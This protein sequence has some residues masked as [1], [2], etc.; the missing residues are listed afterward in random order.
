MG[1]HGMFNFLRNWQTAFQGGGSCT[2]L[3]FCQ[4]CVR[5]PVPPHP[6]QLLVLSAF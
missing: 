3:Q 4:Q 1:P 6:C 5:V 2:I